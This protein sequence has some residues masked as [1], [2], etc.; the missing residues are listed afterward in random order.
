[1]AY[2]TSK[3]QEGNHS[4]KT[5]EVLSVCFVVLYVFSSFRLLFSLSTLLFTGLLG[6]KNFSS[7]FF[8]LFYFL[9]NFSIFL[10]SFIV[11]FPTYFYYLYLIL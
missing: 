7:F 3:L 11:L 1:M 10:F 4:L 8:F 9:L 6:F 5:T 2:W